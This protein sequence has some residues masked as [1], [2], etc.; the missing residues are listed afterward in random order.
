M[1]GKKVELVDLVM[2]ENVS[3]IQ[4]LVDRLELTSDEVI[5]LI[6]ELLEEGKLHGTLTSDGARF[7]KSEVKLSDAPAIERNVA[8]PSFISFNTRPGIITAIIGFILIAVG[9]IVNA[10]SQDIIE[11]SFAATLLLFG[12]LILLSGLYCLSQRKTPA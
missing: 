3:A 4:I 1:S 5:D 9:I 2:K 6:G 12:I 8:P 7:F 10:N 11:Q